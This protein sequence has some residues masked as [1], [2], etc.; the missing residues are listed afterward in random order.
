MTEASAKHLSFD[1][2]CGFAR[3]AIRKLTPKIRNATTNKNQRMT[4]FKEI[5][6]GCPNYGISPYFDASSDR[7][8]LFNR[9]CDKIIELEQEV[10]STRKQ[11]EV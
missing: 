11:I 5:F 2:N 9:H 8:S 1:F 7:G 6:E 4:D 10:A 3:C